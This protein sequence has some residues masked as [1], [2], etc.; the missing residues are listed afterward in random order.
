MV[1]KEAAQVQ[2]DRRSRGEPTL[3][4][5]AAGRSKGRGHFRARTGRMPVVLRSR[6]G[7]WI[8]FWNRSCI[9][10]DW[11]G[12]TAVAARRAVVELDYRES[13]RFGVSA[14]QSLLTC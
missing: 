4:A 14:A 1:A 9:G 3:N 2:A 5:T 13:W 11:A 10:L 12:E 8:L 7:G 6:R